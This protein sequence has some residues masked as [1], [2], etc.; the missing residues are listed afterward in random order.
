MVIRRDRKQSKVVEQ[1]RALFESDSQEGLSDR[2]YA[3]TALE[4]VRMQTPL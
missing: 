4:E 1:E 3:D 2:C